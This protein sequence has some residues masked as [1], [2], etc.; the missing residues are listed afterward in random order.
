MNLFTKYSRI[1]NILEGD[2]EHLSG[3]YVPDSFPHRE[4][5]IDHIVRVL[6]SILR[7]TRPS[8]I[9]IYGKTGTGKTSTTHYVTKMLSEASSDG[10]KV[11]YVNC[12]VYDSP[13]SI[14]ITIVN[15]LSESESDMIP[16]LGWP[17]D[18]IYS[19]LISRINRRKGF[20]LLVLDEV[21]KLIEKNGGDSL[22]VILKVLDDSTV[23]RTSLIGI[24]NDAGFLDGL[25]P[26]VR[27]RMN[28]ESV[29][30]TP[31]NASDLRDI[32]SFRLNG[33]VKK[34]TVTE[35]AVNLCAAI[36]AQEH[37]D[38]RKALDL[39]R[40]AIEIALREGREQI[41]DE[42]IYQARDK[43]EM[44][45]VKEA[46][47]TLPL[48]SK[49]VM[50]SS[51]VTQELNS[52]LMVTGEIFA[53]YRNICAE[54]GFMPLTSRRV[55]DILSELED[56]GLLSAT[57]KS[58]GRYGRTRF[59]SVMGQLDLFKKYILEDENLSMFRGSKV[60]RQ[61]RFENVVDSRKQENGNLEKRLSEIAD[62]EIQKD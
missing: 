18:R 62:S 19:E 9:L 55:S 40:I 59:I 28:Q 50:L 17:L 7:H 45:V 57:T 30:F 24:T 51:V 33:V 26:R 25:E 53:N 44:D 31:Y 16:P 2:L 35:S 36:G 5:E 12:Q 60:T 38:A 1:S 15:T 54:L 52:K 23:S 39:M 42:E 47:K 32:I 46:I 4:T 41:T 3:S 11:C 58:M 8:N 56:F 29:L 10:V 6:S 22:Y 27:S 21:D 61:S 13:Y 14:L 20:Y 43:F 49:I 48:Q 34:N 37:G